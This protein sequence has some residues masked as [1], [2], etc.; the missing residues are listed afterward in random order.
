MMRGKRKLD[1]LCRAI[2]LGS[3]WGILWLFALTHQ[4][5]YAWI[6]IVLLL[7]VNVLASSAI[8]AGSLKRKH[9]VPVFLAL[10]VLIP[11]L[12]GGS[13]LLYKFFTFRG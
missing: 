8:A 11:L 5:A 9:F 4:A 13:L 12:T 3:Y 1:K 6:V 10:L 2:L 7:M